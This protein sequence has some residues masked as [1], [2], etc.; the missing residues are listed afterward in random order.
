MKEKSI[1]KEVEDTIK[2]IR[3]AKGLIEYY[4]EKVRR[5]RLNKNS[6]EGVIKVYSGLILLNQG[7]IMDMEELIKKLQEERK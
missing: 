1:T 7:L 4:E 6:K 5:L 3:C 2:F